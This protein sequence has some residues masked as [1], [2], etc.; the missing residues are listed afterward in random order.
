MKTL[1][2]T[3][4]VATAFAAAM[5]LAH[6]DPGEGDG[7]GR[8]HGRM[9]MHRADGP[10]YGHGGR[11]HGGMGFGGMGFGGMSAGGPMQMFQEFDTNDDGRLTQDE[12]NAA[13]AQKFSEANRDGQ[14]GVTIEEFEPFFWQQH[15]QM[16]VR[17]FQFLDTDGD[18]EVTEAELSA[19][20]AGMV[21]RMDRNGD[22]A[23]SREDRRGGRDRGMR[24]WFSSD[25]DD[26]RGPGRGPG[27]G[28]GPGMMQ[29]PADAPAESDGN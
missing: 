12:I 6:A 20:T 25:D 29:G 1:T 3:A 5:P 18:G 16:M 11:G 22:G 21:E 26:E 28:M 7:W 24:G 23:L 2:F 17:A 27:N 19:R 10:G 8:H 13:Q 14:G 4:I 15:R 9:G